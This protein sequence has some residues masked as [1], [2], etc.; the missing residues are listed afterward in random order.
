VAAPPKK[1]RRSTIE[2]VSGLSFFLDSSIMIP[3]RARLAER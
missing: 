2:F 3:P 1:S